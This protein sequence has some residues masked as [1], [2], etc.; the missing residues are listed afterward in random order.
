MK[1]EVPSWDEIYAMCIELGQKV[2]DS[3]FVPDALIGIAR[4]GWIPARILSDLFPGVE[5]A[6]MRV[7][8]YED[9]GKVGKKPVVS[10]PVSVDVRG[11]K[12]LVVDD[13]ADTGESLLAVREHVMAAGAK[14]LR[15]ATLHYKPHSKVIPDYYARRTSAWIVY[16][17]ERFEF[18]RSTMAK[19]RAEGKGLDEVAGYLVEIGL[20]R[21]VVDRFFEMMKK[22]SN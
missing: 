8:F 18:M 16:P 15:L 12:V 9:V 4:G 20:D 2:R 21:F 6:S 19:M 13:V 5:V 17:H 22:P 11:R 1:Y 7:V 3:G 14:E 10:Q